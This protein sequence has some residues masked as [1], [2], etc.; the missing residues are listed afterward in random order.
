MRRAS[1]HA[2]YQRWRRRRTKGP[3]CRRGVSSAPW[4]SPWDRPHLRRLSALCRWAG[5][6]RPWQQRPRVVSEGGRASQRLV[7]APGGRRRSK[8]GRRGWP[9]TR[10]RR[11]VAVGKAALAAAAREEEGAARGAVV[12]AVA[13]ATTVAPAAATAG[14]ML[15]GSREAVRTGACASAAGR[16]GRMSMDRALRCWHRRRARSRAV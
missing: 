6:R 4:T 12:A 15:S 16:W 10:R 11:G 14:P 1:C 3:T 9:G 5:R 2:S 8:S 7:P 13:V